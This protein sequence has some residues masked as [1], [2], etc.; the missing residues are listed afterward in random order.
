MARTFFE[1]G[2]HTDRYLA[3]HNVMQKYADDINLLV[4]EHTDIDLSSEFNHV[5]QWA[6]VSNMVVNRIKTKESVPMAL[7]K[8]P[9]PPTVS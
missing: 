6:Q 8:V 9:L 5:K 2:D 1:F 7:S 4:P 3:V